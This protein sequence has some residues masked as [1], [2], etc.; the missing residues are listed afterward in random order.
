M[1][2]KPIPRSLAYMAALVV[3][4]HV[5][6]IV[7]L[8]TSPAGAL[9][10]NL[11]QIFCS[12]LAAIM[13]FRAAR[14]S[15]G[16][17]QS[18]WTLVGF[19]IG[20]W[21]VGD[22]GWTYYE[23]L[24]R[25]EPPAGSLI[26]FLFDTHGMFFVMAIFLNQEKT[27]SRVETEET[28]DFI[29][30]GILFFLVYFGTYYLPSLALS[31]QTAFNREMIV[32]LWRDI[33]IVLLSVLQWRRARFPEVRKLYG[34]LALYYL[35]YSVGSHCI[36]AYQTQQEVPTGT[37]YDLAWS[38]PLL[39]GAFWAA[40]WQPDSLA[41]SQASVRK[42]TLTSILITNG[43][44]AFVPLAILFMV[45]EL[46]PGWKW[47]RYSLL[48]VSF[49]CYALRIALG[50]F[51]QQQ[52]E[53]MVRR[54]TLAMDN[55][56]DGI[57]LLDERGIHIYANTAFA[58]M[59]GFESSERILGQ[60]WRN[61]YAFQEISK[62]E[63]DVR[64]SLQQSG[65]WSSPLTLRRPNG[66][67]IPAELIVYLM[68]DGGTVCTCRDL[69]QREEA[70]KA[71]EQ[72]E[73]KY[74]TLVEQVNAISYIAEIGMDGQWHYVSPQVEPIL[75]YTPDEWLAIAH[76]WSEVIHPDDLPIVK[77]AEESSEKG[78]PFQAE[79]RVRRKD[80]REVWLNDTGVVVK[81]GNARPVMEG[82]IV[83]ITERKLL[84]TQLQQSRKME[85]VGRLAGGIAHDFN[86][87][88]TIITG[89]T[90]LALSRPTVPLDLRNDIERI[91][92]ASARAAALVRQLLAFS[93]KQV[94]QPKTLDLNAIVVNMDKL[95]RRLID[96]HIEMITRVQDN[97][98]KVK[99][100]P[101]Q[102]EQVI[103]NL[104]VN[105]RDA[106]PE[107]GR[108][109]L[110][111]SN[112]ALDPA[113]AFDH[114][115]V[116]PGRYVMLAVSD[117]GVGMDAATIAHIFEPFYTTKE[118]GRGTGLGLSTVYG[119][120]KQ[121]GGYIWVYSEPGKGSTFKVYLPR[122]EDLVEP[123]E[124]KPVPLT[125]HR[126]TEVVLL[127]E[128]EEAVRDL[129]HTILVGHGYEVIVALDPPHAEA[130]ASKFP[131]EIHLLLTDVVMPGTSGLELAARIMVARPGIRVLY[132]SGYTE[133]V[134]TS[135][136]M[137]ERGL[138]FL[139]KPFSP[140]V[141]VQKIREVLSRT[142]PAIDK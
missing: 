12:M 84:E 34:G 35:I 103:M 132:M 118:S 71:R 29:Q 114:V 39:Y 93:R 107:G 1:S 30:V 45:A 6:S 33:G 129:V 125:D 75:G 106:M 59:F 140:A 127:V 96:D 111:T 78:E 115:S 85:A 97:L 41:E 67:Q 27:D 40:T 128:D 142:I 38:V 87:L 124:A 100:D 136:G 37:W 61:V 95:L 68:P 62:L 46:G 25:S 116:K 58:N 90:D 2:L 122:V 4:L 99:A 79:Y 11:L 134:I 76:R 56:E 50:Q 77:A 82:I 69:S 43:M 63:S 110:E 88:L 21:G 108:L 3:T 22:L 53:E 94:L 28:L 83:D 54:Q 64:R 36:D 92:N 66:T 9:I 17:T 55:S 14:K 105:A 126:A 139:Q 113:Y 120:V 8:G 138:A 23:S 112:V 26:R 10:G 133:N 47:L 15:S 135:G 123:P 80:G 24:L 81:G 51:R 70:E 137:L 73:A 18:F 31:Q 48:G 60:P 121:S 89:Y 44:F 52:D 131:G 130:I 57:A 101:A 5:C 49:A 72:A 65:K 74:R 42:K 91:E 102:V 98:G 117:T 86:N 141:L 13:C 109:V 119:I 104:V 16:F 32:A 20:I 7:F 19:G